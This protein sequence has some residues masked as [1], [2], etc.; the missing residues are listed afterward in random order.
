M[1]CQMIFNNESLDNEMVRKI[2][3]NSEQ[4]VE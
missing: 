1:K 2:L 3:K 4:A